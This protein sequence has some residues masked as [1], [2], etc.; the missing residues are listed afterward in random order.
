MDLLHEDGEEEEERVAERR[1]FLF[2]LRSMGAHG[3][4]F[5]N[6]AVS[7]KGRR[8]QKALIKG[9][10]YYEFHALLMR[11]VGAVPLFM[12]QTVMTPMSC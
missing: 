12:N 11:K 4:G 2:S 10:V 6:C 7:V 9:K 8:E 3:E 5:N 1:P